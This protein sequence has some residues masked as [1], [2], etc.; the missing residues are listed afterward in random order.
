VL[1]RTDVAAHGTLLEL[2][3]KPILGRVGVG[4]TLVGG[5]HLDDSTLGAATHSLNAVAGARFGAVELRLDAYNVLGLV[6]PDDEE[7]YVSNW[8][9]S[10][11]P[12]PASV[13]RH[14]SAAPPRTLLVTLALHL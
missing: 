4:Y 6:Y 2:R 13:A 9:T 8:S 12:R 14:I 5:R 3:G 7:I 1:F 10:P 11:T